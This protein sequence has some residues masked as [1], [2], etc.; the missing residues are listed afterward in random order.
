[1]LRRSCIQQDVHSAQSG[2]PV[3]AGELLEDIA[4]LCK[5]PQRGLLPH[6]SAKL[7]DVRGGHTS[8]GFRRIPEKVI[9]PFW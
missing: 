9:L 4:E 2:N 1:M 6:W 3:G 5:V 7:G 8:N